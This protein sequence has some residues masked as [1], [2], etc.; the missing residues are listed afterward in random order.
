MGESWTIGAVPSPA[1]LTVCGLPGALSVMVKVPVRL[2]EAV[3]TK[4][5]SIVQLAPAASALVVEQLVPGATLKSPL[6]AIAVMLSGA[7]PLLVSVTPTAVLV[8]P[9]G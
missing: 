1:R 2:P 7:A 5:T 3:G 6:A 4:L 9:T 8:V